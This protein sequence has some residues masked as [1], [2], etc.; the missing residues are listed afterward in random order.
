MPV[1]DTVLCLCELGWL[2][3]KVSS[4]IQACDKAQV[5][6]GLA[7]QAFSFALQ[8]EL[9]DYYRLLDV[10]EQELARKIITESTPEASVSS[11]D[12][13]SDSTKWV[14]SL[15]PKG[16]SGLTLLRLRAW[17]QEPMDRMC[18]MARLVD[19]ASPLTGG[20][21]VY[22]FFILFVIFFV[23]CMILFIFIIEYISFSFILFII[24]R[25]IV[26]FS[27]I[28]SL[29]SELVSHVYNLTLLFC[30]RCC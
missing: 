26:C 28:C 3:S 29:V 17:M 11:E 12:I 2:Y 1:K 9:S 23:L 18:M 16:A 6:R 8:E 21:Y 30:I 19:S 27:C 4:H 20:T 14:T 7:V 13:P 22:L 24:V 25:M 5:S 10:L 15:D